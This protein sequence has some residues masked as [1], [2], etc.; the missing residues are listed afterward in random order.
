MED[1]SLQPQGIVM[2][3]T[4]GLR[5]MVEHHV[6]PHSLWEQKKESGS[7]LPTVSRL[8]LSIDR[9]VHE[10]EDEVEGQN[11]QKLLPYKPLLTTINHY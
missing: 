2:Q 3:D 6:A 10:H 5:N 8:P 11:N 4:E 1:Q 7:H 9:L